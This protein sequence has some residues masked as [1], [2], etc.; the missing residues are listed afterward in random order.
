MCRI[1]FLNEFEVNRTAETDRYS[2][3]YY[4]EAIKTLTLM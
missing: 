1:T 2:I 3:S 4:D